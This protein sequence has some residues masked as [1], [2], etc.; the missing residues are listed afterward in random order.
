VDK[1]FAGPATIAVVNRRALLATVCCTLSGFAGCHAVR[2]PFSGDVGLVD[3]ESRVHPADVPFVERGVSTGDPR[4]RF[5]LYRAAPPT[6][7]FTAAGR[8]A[9]LSV[10]A[11]ALDHAV[12]VLAEVRSPPQAAA[13]LE[14]PPDGRVTWNGW[15][16]LHVPLRRRP[17]ERSGP[18]PVVTTAVVTCRCRA[19]PESAYVTVDSAE[20]RAWNSFVA[21]AV[22]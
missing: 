4:A 15:N 2:R 11:A 3:V 19:D 8:E 17:V 21:D 9:G 5:A 22:T 18:S 7:P 1:A 13:Q 6:E 14:P 20:G 10:D 12:V 16:Q